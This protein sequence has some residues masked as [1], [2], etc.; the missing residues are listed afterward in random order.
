MAVLR[1]GARRAAADAEGPGTRYAV[2]LQGCSIRCAGCCNP[3]LFDPAGGEGIEVSSLLRE[4]AEARDAIEGVSVLG[5]EPFDQAQ[6]LSP[7]V[8]GVRELGLGVIVFTGFSLEQL[9][10]R[11][12]TAVADV[13]AAT[14]V[15]VDGRYDAALPETHRMW[16][17]SANQR[18]HYLTRRYSPAIEAGP[19]GRAVDSIEI[20]ID[21]CGSVHLNGWPLGMHASPL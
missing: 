18:F 10:E 17:G 14:D 6:A 19:G 12:D 20:S 4:V 15:V 5:G 16:A 7:F 21:P 1:V 13:L 11:D 2:W 3:H 8:Q 9:R